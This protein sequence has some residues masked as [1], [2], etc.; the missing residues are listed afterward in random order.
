M[1][2]SSM[3]YTE[4]WNVT[5]KLVRCCDSKATRIV[6]ISV[7]D[8]DATDSSADEGDE[9]MGHHRRVKKHVN[10]IRM[11][12]CGKYVSDGASEKPL[13][14]QRAKKNSSREQSYY[15]EGKK[16]RGVR[17][18]RWGRWAAE[19]RDP[20]RRTRVWLGTFDTAEEAAVIYDQAAIRLRGPNALT[21]FAKPPVRTQ[22]PEVD[23]VTTIS[24]YDSGKDSHSLCSPISVLRF[25]STEEAG[26]ESQPPE[27]DFTKPVPEVKERVFTSIQHLKGENFEEELKEVD[28]WRSAQLVTEG[29]SSLD[30]DCLIL[31]PWCLKQFLDLQTPKPLFQDEF[32]MEEDLTDTSVHYDG[33]FGSCTWE[34]FGDYYSV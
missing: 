28:G 24:G 17:Q 4:H 33:D 7:T 1:S 11:E 6:R 29:S 30:H 12:D 25:Q 8:G 10:E 22:T 19:I 34:D 20:L 15:P 21:N 31:D 9:K 27:A 16:Y 32:I 2:S 3:K 26:A 5:N 13:Q 18:R 14:K 23:M